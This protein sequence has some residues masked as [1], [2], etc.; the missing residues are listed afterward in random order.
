MQR[1]ATQTLDLGFE[2]GDD[3][4]FGEVPGRRVVNLV[5]LGNCAEPDMCPVILGWRGILR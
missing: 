2:K 3:L 4:L 1:E 5:E